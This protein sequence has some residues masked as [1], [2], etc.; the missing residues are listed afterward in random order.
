M[1]IEQHL[2]RRESVVRYRIGPYIVFHVYTCMQLHSTLIH[3][4]A[5]RASGVQVALC[6]P[7]CRAPEHMLDCDSQV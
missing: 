7:P 2:A 4:D 3:F 6:P 1:R 5:A